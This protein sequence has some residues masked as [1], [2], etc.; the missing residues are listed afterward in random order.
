MQVGIE[1][2]PSKKIIIYI[3][4]YHQPDPKKRKRTTFSYLHCLIIL[5]ARGGIFL[6]SEEKF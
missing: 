5:G 1:N 2:G 4:M 6:F 3:Y